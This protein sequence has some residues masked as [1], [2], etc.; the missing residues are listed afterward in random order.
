MVAAGRTV[1]RLVAESIS[2][3]APPATPVLLLGLVAL[4]TLAAANLIAA[5]PARAASRTHP[6]TALRSE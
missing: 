4:A 3:T 1:W 6:A 2:S 5:L